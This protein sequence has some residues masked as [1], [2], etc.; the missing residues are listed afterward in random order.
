[1]EDELA[2]EQQSAGAELEQVLAAAN[3]PQDIEYRVQ[4]HKGEATTM[5]GSAIELFKP[6]MVI[7]GTVANE[8]MKIILL[9]NTAE[10]IARQQKANIL[11][12]K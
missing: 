8:G 2:K 12:L 7:L 11:I 9:G 6:P 5:L 4:L 10:S 1:M 3:I